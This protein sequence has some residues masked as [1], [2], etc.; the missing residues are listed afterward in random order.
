MLL[1]DI[2]QK[3]FETMRYMI[4]TDNLTF[5]VFSETLS[6]KSQLKTMIPNQR[7]SILLK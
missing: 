2:I 1:K 6:K 7:K 5:C 3:D 4:K